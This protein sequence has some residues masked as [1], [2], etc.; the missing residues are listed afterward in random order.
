M[1]RFFGSIKREFLR[2]IIPFGEIGLRHA[3][4]EYLAHYPTERPHQGPDRAIIDP[5]TR[6]DTENSHGRRDGPL[7]YPI[8]WDST[9]LSTG[10]CLRNKEQ[11][12]GT[13]RVDNTQVGLVG[14]CGIIDEKRLE[15]F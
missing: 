13:G 6:N 15:G 3:I 8:G 2:R 4:Q 5:P 11:A 9:A 7:R 10:S 12:R 1:E 14:W